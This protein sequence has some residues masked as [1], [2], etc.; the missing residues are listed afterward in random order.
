MVAVVDNWHTGR[1]SERQISAERC[2]QVQD[3]TRQHAKKSLSQYGEG[4]YHAP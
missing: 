1:I 3:R 2:W 4:V